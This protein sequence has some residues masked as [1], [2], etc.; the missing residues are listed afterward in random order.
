MFTNIILLKLFLGL[1]LL[2][3]TIVFAHFRIICAQVFCVK[4]T[5]FFVEFT[6]AKQT[7]HFNLPLY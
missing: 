5:D 2:D 7:Q 3:F 1:S 6:L 4:K